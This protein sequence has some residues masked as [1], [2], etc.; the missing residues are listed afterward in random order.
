[1]YVT[2][3]E[4]G[5]GVGASV[6]NGRSVLPGGG[7]D[8]GVGGTVAGTTVRVGEGRGEF[9]AVEIAVGGEGVCVDVGRVPRLQEASNKESATRLKA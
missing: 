5:A 3:P 7:V 9:V 8:V 4:I 1:M 6:L 2:Q